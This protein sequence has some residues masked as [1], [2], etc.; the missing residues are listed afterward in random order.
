MHEVPN[1]PLKPV[2]EH[3]KERVE[4]P[5][6]NMWKAVRRLQRRSPKD[7]RNSLSF[8]AHSAG[9]DLS[10]EALFTQPADDA[11]RHAGDARGDRSWPH[12][13]L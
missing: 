7:P 2:G 13:Y 8:E 1:V 6:E 3:N 11:P 4:K 10:I 12:R 9:F 5:A